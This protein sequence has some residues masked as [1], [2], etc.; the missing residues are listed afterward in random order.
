MAKHATV[1]AETTTDER[2][3]TV[4]ELIERIPLDRSTIWKMCRDGRFPRPIQ[5][6]PSR[7]G[8]RWTAVLGWLAEREANPVESR[9]YFR[10]AKTAAP[11]PANR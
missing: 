8:W 1:S 3:V 11:E 5:L 7:I 4:E 2:I 6:T 9:L 10:K